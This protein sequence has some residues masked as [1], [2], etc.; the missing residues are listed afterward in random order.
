MKNIFICDFFLHFHIFLIKK[1]LKRGI[2]SR[3]RMADSGGGGRYFCHQC[4]V[5]IPRV[6]E[7][8][9]CP[10]CNSGFIGKFT[11]KIFVYP[12]LKT[13]ELDTFNTDR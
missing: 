4:N 7:D 9:C 10:V 2:F 3:V 6:S 12:E 11:E 13:L 8:F 1:S 5:E